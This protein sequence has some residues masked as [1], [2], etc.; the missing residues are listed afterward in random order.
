MN[1]TC[2]SSSLV[3]NKPSVATQIIAEMIVTMT[4]TRAAQA[5]NKA[6]FLPRASPNIREV[7]PANATENCACPISVST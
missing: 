5:D 3:V 7:N 6:D 1:H 2:E 4:T